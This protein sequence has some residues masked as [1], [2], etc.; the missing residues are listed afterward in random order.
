M[1][2]SSSGGQSE[3]WCPLFP[4]EEV[5]QIHEDDNED[6]IAVFTV[7][8]APSEEAKSRW[9]VVVE[10]PQPPVKVFTFEANRVNK[11]TRST[12]Y[13]RELD[14]GKLKE[15]GQEKISP[16]R[17]V[18]IARNVCEDQEIS[19]IDQSWCRKFCQLILSPFNEDGHWNLDYYQLVTLNDERDLA[20]IPAPVAVC[21]TD[22][23]TRS[24]SSHLFEKTLVF[25]LF[26]GQDLRSKDINEY[27][28]ED[29]YCKFYL[30]TRPLKYTPHVNAIP[31]S[32][33]AIVVEYPE[34]CNSCPCPRVFTFEATKGEDG[35]VVA[36]RSMEYPLNRT[37]Y[38]IME[39]CTGKISPK[40]LLK[41]AQK[42]DTIGQSYEL[43]R[44]NCQL[45][46]KQFS[47]DL[48]KEI[49]LNFLNGLIL[50]DVPDAQDK[51]SFFTSKGLDS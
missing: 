1:S 44:V 9:A 29:R 33:W 50:E 6:R 20:Q 2:D 31:L 34:P 40:K 10:F 28:D 48:Q 32:H 13:P 16:K 30:Y 17:L 23:F 3:S 36:Y 46:C 45:F 8:H 25:S 39:W 27:D 38:H 15:L 14:G 26:S 24:S 41:V 4:P 11:I 18:D 12:R 21:M 19:F 51:V 42:N 47:V 22:S 43:L 35:K 49:K 7:F 37:R 5:T